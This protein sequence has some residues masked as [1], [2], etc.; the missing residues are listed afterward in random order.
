MNNLRIYPNPAQNQVTIKS[1]TAIEG[2]EV[3]NMIGQVVTPTFGK[4]SG[5]AAS[6]KEVLLDIRS[7]PA[8]VYFV[9][10]NG[11]DGYRDGGRFLKE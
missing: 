7:L 1:T 4:G 11:A 9:K 8:G 2:V 6:S 5:Q 10:V 3:V